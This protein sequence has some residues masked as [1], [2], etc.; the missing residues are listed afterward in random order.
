MFDAPDGSDVSLLNGSSPR[1]VANGKR[2]AVAGPFPPGATLVQVAYSFPYSGSNVTIEQRLPLALSQVTLMAQKVGNMPLSVPRITERREV[3]AQGDTRIV[4]Q[5]GLKAGEPL[6]VSFSGLPH[7][8]AWPRNLALAVASLIL[9]VGGWAGFS[10]VGS[11][12][13]GR[14][15]RARGA[16]RSSVCRVDRARTAA[17]G[18]PRRSFPGRRLHQ[19]PAAAHDGAG[20]HLRRA[21]LLTI[22]FDSITFADVT[23]DFGRRRAFEPG[24]CHLPRRRSRRGARAERRREDDPAARGSH[25]SQTV[26]RGRPIRRVAARH[27]C[28]PCSDRCGRPRPV[29]IRS[30][31]RRRT[32]SFC[33]T[34][35]CSAGR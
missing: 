11:R 7:S 3:A 28:R 5:G 1:A 27:G 16:A 2:V 31:R 10:A 21:R 35:R 13:C 18:A 25:S 19:A 33:S 9:G 34:V 12:A 4:A 8:P 22:D 23:V 29:C 20:I 6:S 32:W 24:R 30:S 14:S 15:R 26:F 17:A